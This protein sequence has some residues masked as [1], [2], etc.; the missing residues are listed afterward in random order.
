MD[1]LP[2]LSDLAAATEQN[3]TDFLH[4]D[5]ALCFT[6]ADLVTTELSMGERDAAQRVRAKAEQGYATISRFLP[7]V[8]NPQQRDDIE[9]KLN[10]LR[11]TL[12]SLPV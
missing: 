9:R 12:D 3:L 1:D 7:G 11:S 8:H 4:T 10:N 5:L 2:E 6:F